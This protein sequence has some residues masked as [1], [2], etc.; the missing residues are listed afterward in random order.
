[1]DKYFTLIKKNVKRATKKAKTARVV[2]KNTALLISR[3]GQK[4]ARVLKSFLS[5]GKK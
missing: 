2:H 3:I 1:V 5:G 4:T